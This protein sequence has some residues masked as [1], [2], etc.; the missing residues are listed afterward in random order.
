MNIQNNINDLIAKAAAVEDMTVAQDS[1]EFEYTPPPAGKTVARFVAYI[2]LGKQPQRPFQGKA[3]PP[4][5]E[6]RLVFEL[7]HPK[8]NI[9]T[10]QVDGKD[11]TVA[12]TIGMT[13]A[14]KLGDKAKFKK[15]FDMMRYGRD[16]VKHMAQMLGN[17]FIVT[18]F[19]NEV[20]KDGKKTVYANLNDAAGTYHIGSPFIVD[21]LTEE[22]KKVPVPANIRPLQLFLFDNPTKETWDSLFI[23]GHRE[24]KNGDQ[25]E[26][27]SNNWLQ[28]RIMS[29]VNY[30]GSAL[31]T[32]LAGVADLPTSEED[33]S[34]LDGIDQDVP[35][36]AAESPASGKQ[37]APAS[38]GASKPSSAGDD[39]LAALGLN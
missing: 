31:H 5:E 37:A 33:A 22:S 15:I 35:L 12:D 25:V 4:C 32:L 14:K 16:G 8:K 11:V 7:L 13:V 38:S 2:E 28:E 19:H 17:E 24:I 30:Q 21:P 1:V 9:R 23:D 39:A 18:V 26:Q 3:K 29:A 36:D 6:V 20:E 27:R 10:I 34:G